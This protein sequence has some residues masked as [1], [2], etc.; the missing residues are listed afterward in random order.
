RLCAAGRADTSC[1]GARNRV[2]LF[3]SL[4]GAHSASLVWQKDRELE[5][6]LRCFGDRRRT[7]R[8]SGGAVTRTGR[9]VGRSSGAED[10]SSPKSLRRIP[11]ADQSFLT[12]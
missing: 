7:S 2:H 12:S 9:V 3:G 11:I 8:S 1:P 6:R 5:K 10:L 4:G